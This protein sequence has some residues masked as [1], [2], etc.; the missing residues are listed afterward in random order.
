MRGGRCRFKGPFTPRENQSE[1]EN[2]QRINGKLQRKFYKI[3]LVTESDNFYCS[4][5][6]ICLFE[7]LLAKSS[8]K[9]MD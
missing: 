5:S 6:S 3:A 4:I 8:H 9:L 7:I 1:S 2:D